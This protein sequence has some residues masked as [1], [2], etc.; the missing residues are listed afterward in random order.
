LPAE[1]YQAEE[2]LFA[3]AS[4]WGYVRLDGNDYSIP[5][6]LAGR[7]LAAKLDATSV[8][9]YDQGRLATQHA[10]CF[11]HHQVLT[12][13]GHQNRPWS[14]RRET[15]P[16]FP[17]ELVPGFPLPRQAALVVEQRNLSVYDA[18]MLEEEVA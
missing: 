11:G 13:P 14:L 7:R 2:I 5:L 10:R 4:R 18:L 15:P 12:L 6:I 9:I 3:K 17:R 8:R 1:P 16:V